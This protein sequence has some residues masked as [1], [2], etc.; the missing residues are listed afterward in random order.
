MPV[1]RLDKLPLR[2][3]I[4]VLKCKGYGRGQRR[5]VLTNPERLSKGFILSDE[6]IERYGI[7]CLEESELKRAELYFK[8]GIL[9]LT[10]IS[11]TFIAGYSGEIKYAGLG[12][13]TGVGLASVNYFQDK[14]KIKKNN[15]F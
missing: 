15:S 3:R 12:F 13:L 8:A 6:Q 10:T 14:V 2:G 1:V 9:A 4:E 11:G 5:E 7:R